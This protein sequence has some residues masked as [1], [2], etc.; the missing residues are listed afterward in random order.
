MANI[1]DRI[2]VKL[3]EHGKSVLDKDVENT[4][5]TSTIKT[6]ISDKTYYPYHI[7]KDGYTE[8]TLWDFMRIFGTH[9]WNG[10]PQIIED[11]EIIFLPKISQ[12]YAQG[13]FDDWVAYAEDCLHKNK[14]EYLS[15]PIWLGGIKK[16]TKDEINQVFDLLGNH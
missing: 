15:F 14:W 5:S 9:F 4:L 10:C 8:I 2:K 6:L 1:N 7:D 3:T 16:L 12:A 11:N 13:L